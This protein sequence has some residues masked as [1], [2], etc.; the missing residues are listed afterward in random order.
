M[1]AG[2]RGLAWMLL[3]LGGCYSYAPIE[4]AEVRPEII[5]DGFISISD[6]RIIDEFEGRKK[7]SKGSA[8]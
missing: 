5:T 8:D 6:G 3:A 2:R 1:K 4:L 7:S